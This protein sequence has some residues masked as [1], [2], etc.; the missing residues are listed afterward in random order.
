ME[1]QYKWTCDNC[2][3]A[4][5]NPMVCGRCK[6]APYCNKE[7]QKSHWKTHKQICCIDIELTPK[8]KMIELSNELIN[9][10]KSSNDL[11]T[12]LGS[13]IN[14]YYGKKLIVLSAILNRK[15]NE[16]EQIEILNMSIVEFHVMSNSK[17]EC[18]LNYGSFGLIIRSERFHVMIH[19]FIPYSHLIT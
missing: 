4:L 9:I 3:E 11:L 18:D 6:V 17:I 12:E 19:G 10:V 7:C 16:F 15:I 8:E 1:Q 5:A 13:N 2:R 14:K